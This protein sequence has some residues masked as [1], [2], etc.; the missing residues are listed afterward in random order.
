MASTRKAGV[1]GLE[2]GPTEPVQ[3]LPAGA[4]AHPL[5]QAQDARQHGAELAVAPSAGRRD[6]QGVPRPDAR[7]AVVV[8]QVIA[9]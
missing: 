2:A 4:E 6:R 8:A 7:A 1:E 9:P 5:P 3:Q